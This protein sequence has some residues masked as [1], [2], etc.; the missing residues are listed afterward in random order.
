MISDYYNGEQQGLLL[1]SL[2]MFAEWNVIPS[3][4]AAILVEEKL[5]RHVEIQ[6]PHPSMP[7]SDIYAVGCVRLTPRG[8][9]IAK[10]VRLQFI[11]ANREENVQGFGQDPYLTD[12]GQDGTRYV[13]HEKRFRKEFEEGDIEKLALLYDRD[14]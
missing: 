14:F 11:M 5:L 12:N 9:K 4:M 8:R 13:M 7:V 1:L 3:S 6:P 2:M 10:K